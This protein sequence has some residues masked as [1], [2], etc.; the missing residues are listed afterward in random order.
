MGKGKKAP[1][2]KKTP[3]FAKKDDTAKAGT[4][5]KAAAK[6]KSAYFRKS[7]RAMWEK[8]RRQRIA[9]SERCI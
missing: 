4:G 1:A 5:L 3:K 2:K 9:L 6:P 8:A 7:W